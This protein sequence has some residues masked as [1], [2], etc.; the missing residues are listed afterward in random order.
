MNTTTLNIGTYSVKALSLRGGAISRH[1][2]P[3]QPG[4]V[5]NGLILQPE[6]VGRVIKSLF[7]SAK[8]PARRVICAVNGLPFSYR[9]LTVP[10]LAKPELNEAVMRMAKKEMS[11]SPDE[12]YLSWRAYPAENNEWQ[13]LV[14]GITRRPVDNLIKALSIAGLRPEILELPHLALASLSPY[15]D[16]VMADFEKD[17]SNIVIVVDGV[18]RAMQMV[19]APGLGASLQDQVGQVMDK[20]ARMVEFYNNTHPQQP[21]KEPVKILIT[22]EMLEDE[23][24]A[25]FFQPP[26]GYTVEYLPAVKKYLSGWPVR[27]YAVNA[28]LLDFPSEQGP[29]QLFN[30]ESI[31]QSRLPQT[32]VA[33]LLK[34]AAVPLALVAGLGLLTVT[35]LSRAGVLEDITKLQADFS[36]SQTELAQKQ[37]AA[38]EARAVQEK[39]DA[40]TSSLAAIE[41]GREE[42]FASRQYTADISAIIASMPE[43]LTINSLEVSGGAIVLEGSAAAAAPVIQYAHNLETAGG[44]YSAIINWIDK[45]RATIQDQPQLAFRMAILQDAKTAD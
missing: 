15:K 40:L 31:I 6:T 25:G 13:V 7:H 18:P 32:D 35:Y 45:P 20:L 33:R 23:K 28:G 1:E 5:K 30:L 8:L 19:P 12:M 42:I 27:Q 17:C 11:I 9:L 3:L 24:A 10:G 22:G 37:S 26:A 21:V 4:D 44:F 16:T 2:A 29:Y 36:R 43:G 41:A 39:I 34:K 14:T 38:T